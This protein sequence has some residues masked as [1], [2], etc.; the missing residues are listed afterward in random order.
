ML[1]RLQNALILKSKTDEEGE[2]FY[3]IILKKRGLF[4]RFYRTVTLSSPVKVNINERDYKDYQKE[5]NE[6]NMEKVYKEGEIA[7]LEEY[8]E[9]LPE[10]TKRSIYKRARLELFVNKTSDI[11]YDFEIQRINSIN[12]P[13]SRKSRLESLEKR[14][15][16]KFYKKALSVFNI[17]PH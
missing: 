11:G 15:S 10:E 5:I 12:Q 13:E 6:G 4:Q 3:T 2:T 16:E 9:E 8:I 17:L 14:L 7:E 1:T